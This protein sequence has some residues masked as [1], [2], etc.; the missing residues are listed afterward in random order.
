[1]P[2]G[3]AFIADRE[4]LGGTLVVADTRNGRVL[5][6]TRS[7]FQLASSTCSDCPDGVYGVPLGVGVRSDKG[8]REVYVTDEYTGRVHVLDHNLLFLEGF[9]TKGTDEG[10]L[11]SPDEIAVAP[12]GSAYVADSGIGAERISK[13][14]RDG[15]F[16]YS[17]A[18]N[19]TQAFV[20]PHGVTLDQQGHI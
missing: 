9:G 3:I 20:Q 1:V 10:N 11:A 13:F 16:L 8:L 19:G 6:F 15:A 5:K 4:G 2:G 12:D 7:G 18:T 17:F 14:R